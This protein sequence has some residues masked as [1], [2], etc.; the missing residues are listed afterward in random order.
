MN[1]LSPP[2]PFQEILYPRLLLPRANVLRSFSRHLGLDSNL[3]EEHN[4]HRIIMMNIGATII[5]SHD[6]DESMHNR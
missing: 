1:V 2:P 5:S 6:D 4:D 3:D